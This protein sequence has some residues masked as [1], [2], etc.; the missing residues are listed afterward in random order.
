MNVA[1]DTKREAVFQ[2]VLS[3]LRDVAPLMHNLWAM[4]GRGQP[5]DIDELARL[6]WYPH[7]PPPERKHRQM[8]VGAFV[9]HLNKRI[10]RHQVTIRPGAVKGTYQLYD[11]A[12]W[13]VQQEAIRRALVNGDPAPVKR[14]PPKN[15][16]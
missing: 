7:A 5:R 15:R 4:L 16:T 8:R 9:A 13:K 11:L 1:I 2:T 14:R 12:D 10:G 6:L 3:Q